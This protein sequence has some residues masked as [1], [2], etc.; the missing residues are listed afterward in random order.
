MA[1]CRRGYP[2]RP[3]IQPRVHL[4]PCVRHAEGALEDPRVGDEPQKGQ[5]GCPWQTHAGHVIDTIIEPPPCGGMLGRRRVDSINQQVGVHEDQW[6]PSPSAAASASATSSS[7][8]RGSPRSTLLVTKAELGLGPSAI[9]RSP[10]RSASFTAAF[11]HRARHAEI[12]AN[13][14]VSLGRLTGRAPASWVP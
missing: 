13:L 11:R 5:N 4:L 12:T 1:I 3:T 9:A 2:C 8:R 7:G 10:R 14:R 6:K